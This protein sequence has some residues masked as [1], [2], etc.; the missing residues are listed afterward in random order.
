MITCT[1]KIN[2]HLKCVIL[3]GKCLS[4]AFCSMAKYISEKN[5]YKFQMHKHF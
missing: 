3:F 5:T 2:T 4:D 1:T